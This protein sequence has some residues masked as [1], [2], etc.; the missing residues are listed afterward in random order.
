MQ[1]SWEYKEKVLVG[2]IVS[3]TRKVTHVKLLRGIG[4]GCDEEAIRVVKMLP[5]FIPGR[6]EDPIPELYGLAIKFQLPK[7]E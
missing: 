7:K 3:E 6:T 2:F 4:K 1:L 5:N